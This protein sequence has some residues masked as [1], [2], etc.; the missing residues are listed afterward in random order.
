M[1]ERSVR[2]AAFFSLLLFATMFAKTAAASPLWTAGAGSDSKTD[3]SKQS[4]TSK[5]KSKDCDNISGDR[6]STKLKAN[7]QAAAKTS[8][9][10]DTSSK[11]TSKSTSTSKAADKSEKKDSKKEADAISKDR[12]STRGLE[13]P[14]DATKD[15]APKTDTT[16]NP[17]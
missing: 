11:D 12:M 9:S 8:D 17:K 14:K 10:A 2:L 1:P 5:E 13:P 15:Q 7:K 6:M 3:C 4:S 16:A